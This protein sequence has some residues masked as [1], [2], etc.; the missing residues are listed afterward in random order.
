MKNIFVIFE[1]MIMNMT[2][3]ANPK[4]FMNFKNMFEH[5]KQILMIQK[6]FMNSKYVHEF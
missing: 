3:V 1:K 5:S 6:I 2:F 4:L